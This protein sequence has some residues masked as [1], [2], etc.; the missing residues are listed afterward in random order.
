[1]QVRVERR[2]TN[3]FRISSD[4]LR[5]ADLDDD[6]RRLLGERLLMQYHMRLSV[7]GVGSDAGLDEV[8]Q[9]STVLNDS[10]L[11]RENIGESGGIANLRGD[12][13]AVEMTQVL[14]ALESRERLPLIT[15]DNS[16]V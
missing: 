12:A 9:H 6:V 16:A 2:R 5:N 10:A 14:G 13:M 15:G 11:D 3:G 1:V 8:D 4:H 7:K